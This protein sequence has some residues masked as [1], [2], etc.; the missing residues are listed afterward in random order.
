[1]IKNTVKEY[2][3]K[4]LK[5]TMKVYLLIFDQ[6]FSGFIFSKKFWSTNEISEKIEKEIEEIQ[7]LDEKINTIHLRIDLNRRELDIWK[8]SKQKEPSTIIDKIVR[9]ERKESFLGCK[10]IFLSLVIY[11]TA[12]LAL[13]FE[14]S[15]TLLLIGLIFGLIFV[16]DW[17]L[18]RF[19]AKRGWYGTNTMEAFEI[20]QFVRKRS[21]DNSIGPRRVF[22]H[23]T[24]ESIPEKVKE[25]VLKPTSIS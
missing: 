18:I 22:H 12:S 15:N 4:E 25:S 23:K 24:T 9:S 17:L 16:M 14:L 3:V 10:I 19:R 7:R 1:M 6:I 20:I 21:N 8:S 13:G 5:Y 11:I 2:I